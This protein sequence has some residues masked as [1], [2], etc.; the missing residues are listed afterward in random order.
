MIATIIDFDALRAYDPRFYSKAIKVF[1]Q[2]GGVHEVD[3]EALP[4]W[5]DRE[6]LSQ[7]LRAHREKVAQAAAAETERQQK[8]QIDTE[9]YKKRIL[10]YSSEQGL[11]LSKENADMI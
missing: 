7:F 2:S 6:R 5:E 4:Y 1:K 3:L 10:Q 11:E 9:A 8:I